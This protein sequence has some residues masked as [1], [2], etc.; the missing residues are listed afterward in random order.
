MS[1]TWIVEAGQIALAITAVVT[2]VAL[3]LRSPVGRWLVR[4]VRE[5]AEEHRLQQM[6]RMLDVTMPG[7]LA[8][9]LYELRVNG[10]GSFRDQ[11][12]SRLERIEQQ[13]KLATRDREDLRGLIEDFAQ[14]DGL[15][16]EPSDRRDHP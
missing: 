7:Y 12:V 10:G 4:Q 14:I 8:P 15:G 13:Q 16:R 5:D 3:V 6:R 9:V 11:I 2:L 1:D